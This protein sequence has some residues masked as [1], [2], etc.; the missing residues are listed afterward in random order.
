MLVNELSAILARL[1]GDSGASSFDPNDVRVP[2]ACFVVARN[3]LGQA[4]GCG[5]F[6]PLESDVA[7]LKRMY[8][9]PGT[10]GLGH[11]VLA[12]LEAR[13]RCLGY[14]AL[15]LETR[16]VNRRA[17]SFYLKNGYT[18]IPNFGHYVGNDKAVCFEKRL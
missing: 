12:N 9:R 16:H 3:S 13:A 15:R 2:R 4:V 6:R 14:K 7:E 11:A 17:V 5:A 10:S 1:T 8:A 18:S